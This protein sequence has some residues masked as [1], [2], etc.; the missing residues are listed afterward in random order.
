[1]TGISLSNTKEVISLFCEEKELSRI[2]WDYPIQEDEI[3]RSS[4]AASGAV[5]ESSR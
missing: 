4:L 3:I 5:F 1:M 2:T